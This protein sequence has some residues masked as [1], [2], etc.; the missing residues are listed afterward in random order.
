MALLA[1]RCC[2]WQPIFSIAMKFYYD[3]SANLVGEEALRGRDPPSSSPTARC[4]KGSSAPGV[5]DVAPF[6]PLAGADDEALGVAMFV[7]WIVAS[8]VPCFWMASTAV[9]QVRRWDMAPP[10]HPTRLLAGHPE[11]GTRPA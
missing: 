1:E 3:R 11:G 9:A 4:T 7:D 5:V 6:V 2:L 8:G 10:L